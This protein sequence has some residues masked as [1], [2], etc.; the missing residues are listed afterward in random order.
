M[1][2]AGRHC[3][4]LREINFW[5]FPDQGKS[6]K[7]TKEAKF[8]IENYTQDTSQQNDQISYLEN[9]T[10]V[11]MG[12]ALKLTQH[13]P[14]PLPWTASTCVYKLFKCLSTIVF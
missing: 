6:P 8:L 10:K 9:Q 12:E 11:F 13:L 7:G 3:S 5:I 2:H 4:S 14:F 1:A